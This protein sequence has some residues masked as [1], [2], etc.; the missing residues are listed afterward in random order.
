MFGGQSLPCLHQGKSFC[1]HWLAQGEASPPTDC[2][3][4]SLCPPQALAKHKPVVLF[5]TH[6]ESS[7]GILQPL[8]GYGELCHR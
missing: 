6:G 3:Q 1:G 4:L 8:E 5:L 7:S 2:P